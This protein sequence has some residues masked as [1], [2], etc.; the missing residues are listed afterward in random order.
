MKIGRCGLKRF[1]NVVV[2]QL[3]PTQK[4]AADPGSKIESQIFEAYPPQTPRPS[5]AAQAYL[6]WLISRTMS[7]LGKS[8]LLLALSIFGDSNAAIISAGDALN[9][10]R[11][12]MGF[13]EYQTTEDRHAYLQAAQE[14]GY[15]CWML[16]AKHRAATCIQVPLEDCSKMVCESSPAGR[17][18]NTR[19]DYHI[20]I[21]NI[22]VPNPLRFTPLPKHLLTPA[23][24]YFAFTYYCHILLVPPLHVLLLCDHHYLQSLC[25]LVTFLSVSASHRLHL[26]SMVFCPPRPL[27]AG[28]ALL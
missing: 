16:P 14:Q 20:I 26:T 15:A 17:R 11:H 9:G 24:S 18:C 21:C 23:C 4:P 28:G 3:V 6:S 22:F 2:Q 25:T 12:V 19:I 10:R 27:G 8:C 5:A 7:S 1:R 13:A